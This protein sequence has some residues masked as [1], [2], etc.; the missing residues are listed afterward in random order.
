MDGFDQFWAIYP[1][2]IAKGDARKA[3]KQT[4]K[5]RPEL[6]QIIKAIQEAKKQ[7]DNPQFIPYPATW[8][9]AE[10]WDDCYETTVLSQEERREWHETAP[11]IE[12]KGAELGL[13]PHDYPNWPT[14]KAA[15]IRAAK[16][17][18]RGVG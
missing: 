12:A 7:W 14:F 11:G 2:K 8:L 9:R 6:T 16:P 17:P 13:Y 15:V 3:W 5:I 4:E 10:R 18:M 1:K